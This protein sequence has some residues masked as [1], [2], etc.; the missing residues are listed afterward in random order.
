MEKKIYNFVINFEKE[1][2]NYYVLGT[3]LANCFITFDDLFMDGFKAKWLVDVI[4]IPKEKWYY[5]TYF[6][7]NGK[8]FNF[9]EASMFFDASIMLCNEISFEDN[10]L[11]NKVYYWRKDEKGFLSEVCPVIKTNIIGN[12]KCNQCENKINYSY[13]SCFI[14][15]H[16]LNEIIIKEELK[17]YQK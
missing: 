13:D 9:L 17:L 11:K 8:Y 4:E 14:V 6:D 3:S 12:H 5:L 15:C 16:K 1:I 2:K 7:S 10:Y